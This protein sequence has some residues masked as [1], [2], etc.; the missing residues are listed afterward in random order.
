MRCLDDERKMCDMADISTTRMT[1]TVHIELSG[2]AARPI[3]RDDVVLM[4]PREKQTD[5]ICAVHTTEY[6]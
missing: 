5:S 4:D 2:V 6:L 1:L 3:P